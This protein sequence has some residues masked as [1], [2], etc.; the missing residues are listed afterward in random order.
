MLTHVPRAAKKHATGVQAV[1]LGLDAPVLPLITGTVELAEQIRVRLM[2][3]HKRL[4]GNPARV[5]RV[6]SGKDPA[7]LPLTDHKHLFILPLSSAKKEG[8]ID[9]LTD[10]RVSQRFLNLRDL[11]TMRT[12][13]V[14]RH[15][16]LRGRASGRR[17]RRPP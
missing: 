2:G 15:V 6:F 9:R 4:V 16:V 11:R 7:G 13:L 3:I 1:L 17:H 12:Q 8:R 5:S 14:Y 10:R